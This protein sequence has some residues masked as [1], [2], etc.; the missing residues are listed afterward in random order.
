MLTHCHWGLPKHE[1]SSVTSNRALRQQIGG[2]SSFP[3][4]KPKAEFVNYSTPILRN[5]DSRYPGT[6]GS[7][8]SDKNEMLNEADE[9][10]S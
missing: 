6:V 7:T 5:I 2:H 8:A 1:A 4:A 3:R 9:D 10:M